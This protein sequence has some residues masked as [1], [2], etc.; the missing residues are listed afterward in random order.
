VIA[1][2]LSGNDDYVELAFNARKLDD[3]VKCLVLTLLKEVIKI[4]HN[5]I[6]FLP[7]AIFPFQPTLLN[8]SK[9]SERCSK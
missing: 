1:E 3:K 2:E 6:R 9:I 5:L 8:R 7:A 4:A